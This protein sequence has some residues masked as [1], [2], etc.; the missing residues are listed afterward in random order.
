MYICTGILS[1]IY[2]LT[3]VS[4]YVLLYIYTRSCIHVVLDP[5]SGIEYC[6]VVINFGGKRAAR[7]LETT[8]YSPSSSAR[9]H[10]IFKTQADNNEAMEGE[11]I[12]NVL[13]KRCED[14]ESVCEDAKV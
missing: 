11:R 14:Y 6:T 7:Y 3:R 13:K 8:L 9:Q 5:G 1:I 4:P 12:L 10:Y 2:A